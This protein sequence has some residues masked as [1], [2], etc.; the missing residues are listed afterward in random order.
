MKTLMDETEE[1]LADRARQSPAAALAPAPAAIGG[2]SQ[3]SMSSPSQPSAAGASD[4]PC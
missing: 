3:P 1:L 4:S 2:W